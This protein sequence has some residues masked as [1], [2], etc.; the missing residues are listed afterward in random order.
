MKS[1]MDYSKIQLFETKP[2]KEVKKID[3]SSFK[4]KFMMLILAITILSIKY[5]IIVPAGVGLSLFIF[6]TK[7]LVDKI[8]NKQ[9]NFL[10]EPDKNYIEM[11]YK[12]KLEAINAKVTCHPE[13]N[14]IRIMRNES[15]RLYTFANSSGSFISLNK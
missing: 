2:I 9:F 7:F 8:R 11:P 6:L 3:Y 4:Y 5:E 1:R 15:N 12:I 13:S 10:P 14:P